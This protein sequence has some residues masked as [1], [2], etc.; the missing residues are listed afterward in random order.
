MKNINLRQALE[1]VKK[2]KTLAQRLAAT[3][4]LMNQTAYKAGQYLYGVTSTDEPKKPTT[5]E[6]PQVLAVPEPTVEPTVEPIVKHAPNQTV[7][8]PLNRN[9]EDVDYFT[10]GL[11][12]I[13]EEL[14][15]LRLAK[16]KADTD[17]ENNALYFKI[18]R[19]ER[20]RRKYLAQRHL[21]QD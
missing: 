8:Q 18:L 20:E 9:Q 21:S 6:T 15:A 7:P 4:K 19:L 11:M 5:P 13:N 3:S 16:E 12:Q 10:N 2:A 17:V 14:K 1:E